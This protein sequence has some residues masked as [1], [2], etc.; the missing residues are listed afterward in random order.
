MISSR[1]TEALRDGKSLGLRWRVLLLVS[2]ASMSFSKRLSTE[3]SVRGPVEAAAMLVVKRP[4]RPR[5]DS[6]FCMVLRIS[7]E[8]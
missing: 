1:A 3:F 2:P 7:A 4:I 5:R 8:L 6:N